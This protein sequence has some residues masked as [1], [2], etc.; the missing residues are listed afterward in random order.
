[1]TASLQL[2]FGEIV[3]SIYNFL[4]LINNDVI[5]PFLNVSVNKSKW[6]RDNSCA[7]FYSSNDKQLSRA[8]LI[9]D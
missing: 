6:K 1:M 4:E 8:M 9:A 5:S 2:N 7:P 3:Y